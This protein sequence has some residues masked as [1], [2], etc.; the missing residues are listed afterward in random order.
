MFK[1]I[2]QKLIKTHIIK[3][4]LTIKKKTEIQF[5]G[6]IL[7]NNWYIPYESIV[8]KEFIERYEN[9]K[10]MYEE[11]KNEINWNNIIYS[12]KLKFKPVIGKSYYLYIDEDDKYFLSLISPKEWK[13]NFVG[14]FKFDHNGK[15]INIQ[16]Y[17]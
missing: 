15:W 10:K 11:L 3:M 14:E 1:K 12:I 4:K 5:N 7:N 2:K 6:E 13:R 8:N 16:T 17:S 9:I